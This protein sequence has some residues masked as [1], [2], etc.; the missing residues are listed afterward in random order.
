MPNSQY[1]GD[2]FVVK[3]PSAALG[4]VTAPTFSGLSS[5]SANIDSSINIAWSAATGSAQSPVRY[6]EYIAEGSVSAGTLFVGGNLLRDTYGLSDIIYRLPNGDYLSK[7]VT[8]TVGVR[9]VSAN[10]IAETNTVIDT[11]VCSGVSVYN[12]PTNPL[13]DD[14]ARIDDIKKLAKTILGNVV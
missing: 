1:F 9:A 6:Q 7:G 13:L 12:I 3:M 10:G 8:Y 5:S 11:V 14:D 4:N 2:N